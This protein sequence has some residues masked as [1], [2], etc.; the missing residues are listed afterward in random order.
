MHKKIE[1]MGEGGRDEGYQPPS[2]PRDLKN[3]P[4]VSPESQEMVHTPQG[5]HVSHLVAAIHPQVTIMFEAIFGPLG[6]SPGTLVMQPEG[7][8]GEG[9]H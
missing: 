4:Q 1:N 8:G 2:T 3:T 5:T 6:C 9:G 7:G